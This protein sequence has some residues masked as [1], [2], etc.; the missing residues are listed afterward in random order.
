MNVSKKQALL[1]SCE[2][3]RQDISRNVSELHGTAGNLLIKFKKTSTIIF[4]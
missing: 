3:L 4:L 1:I 2:L